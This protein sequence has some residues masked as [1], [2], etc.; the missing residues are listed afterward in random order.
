MLWNAGTCCSNAQV[1]KPKGA[2]DWFSC[3]SLGAA[4]NQIETFKL[5]LVDADSLR[6]SSLCLGDLDVQC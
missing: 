2:T 4:V 3:A 5:H 6:L 1:Q